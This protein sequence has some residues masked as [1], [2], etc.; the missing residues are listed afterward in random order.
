M[1]QGRSPD[2]AGRQSGFWFRSKAAPPFFAFSMDRS[3]VKRLWKRAFN[4]TG[5]WEIRNAIGLADHVIDRLGRLGLRE[6]FEGGA[7]GRLY[8]ES[9]ATALTVHLLRRYGNG[10]LA[11]KLYRGGLPANRL[12]R[13]LDYIDAHL[14]GELGLAELAKISGLSPHHFAAAFKTTTG[15]SPHRYV[16][17]HRD[18][19]VE[20]FLGH[21]V[22]ERVAQIAGIVHDSVDATEIID[23]CLHHRLPA[24]P[25]R[26]AVTIRDRTPASNHDLTDHLLCRREVLPFARERH[27]E[28]VD[29]DRRAGP[30]QTQ[31]DSASDTASATFPSIMP[32]IAILSRFFGSQ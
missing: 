30:C 14:R 3:V 24:I 21:L 2:I 1:T 29:D 19:A 20:F 27:A 6:V 12:R 16:I 18:N 7:G 31:R 11:L 9:L 22:E 17:E 32:M 23:R 8:A 10:T 26:D 4:G 5:D 15:S 28:I 25:A 13:V